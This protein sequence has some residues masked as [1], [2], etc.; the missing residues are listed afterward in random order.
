M[1]NLKWGEGEIRGTN[2]DLWRIP[3][4]LPSSIFIWKRSSKLVSGVT[5]CVN[6]RQGWHWQLTLGISLKVTHL[7]ETGMGAY[8]LLFVLFKKMP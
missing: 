1:G 3:S 5:V 6:Q 2:A 8:E 4:P 7:Y